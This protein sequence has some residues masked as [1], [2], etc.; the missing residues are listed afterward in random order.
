[1][2]NRKAAAET[3]ATPVAPSLLNPWLGSNSKMQ[4]ARGRQ[5][6][7]CWANWATPTRTAQMVLSCCM[8]VTPSIWPM[9]SVKQL[10]GGVLRKESKSPHESQNKAEAALTESPSRL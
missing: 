10:W 4:L 6:S 7:K 9:R 3:P 1:M 8:C 2:F 5:P